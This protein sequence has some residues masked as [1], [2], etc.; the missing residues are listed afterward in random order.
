MAT[1]TNAEFFSLL[2]ELGFTER[3]LSAID[4]AFEH[5]PT[6]IVLVLGATAETEPVRPADLLS[7]EVR[8]QHHGLLQGSLEKAILAAR[9][10]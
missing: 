6:G 9:V 4:I 5:R 3:P 2:R 8:L 1:I 7:A 10:N